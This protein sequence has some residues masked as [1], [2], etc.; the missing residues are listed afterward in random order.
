MACLCESCSGG[1]P[2]TFLTVVLARV[3]RRGS[4]ACPGVRQAEIAPPWRSAVS[5]KEGISGFH[6]AVDDARR[7]GACRT[8]AI[9][10]GVDSSGRLADALPRHSR[11][12][13]FRLL[14]QAILLRERYGSPCLTFGLGA[15]IWALIGF[16][17]VAGCR[18]FRSCSWRRS[19]H[20][21]CSRASQAT[22][23][24]PVSPW[25]APR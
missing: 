19:F 9:P 4:P 13:S 22:G 20:S 2:S 12:V 23:A 11:G 3:G 16:R 21:A 17:F 24:E 7:S 8:S 18:S 1:A 10:P 15:A 5:G 14:P 25:P 6:I